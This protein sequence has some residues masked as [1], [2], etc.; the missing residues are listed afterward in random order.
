[1][2]ARSLGNDVTGRVAVGAVGLGV[3]PMSLPFRPPPEQCV[4]TIHAALDAGVRLLDTADA[5]CA[6]P[7]DFGHGETL[8]AQALRG[9]DASQVL[10][11]TKGGHLRP[12]GDEWT[13]DGSPAYLRRACEASLHRLGVEAIGLYQHHRPDPA[14][15]Y[16]DSMGELRRLWEQG[17]VRMV[18]IS[19]AS[20][21]Q[22]Q[23]ARDVL[24]PALVSVQNRFGP[25]S[26]D[27]EATLRYC[28]GHGL[29]FLAWAPLGS[30][31]VA[32]R[33][34]DHYPEL[35]RVAD[36]YGVS[37]QRACLAWLLGSSPVLVPIP[38]ASRPETAA[39]SAAAAGLVLTADERAAL[40]AALGAASN[41]LDSD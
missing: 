12:S 36:R 7:D 22:I 27:E 33:L 24:G 40:D 35:T 38:G 8:I 19:N 9:R 25:G 1:M 23:C 26:S 34:A 21:S 11:A 30:I 17:K 5:Y 15:A 2:H 14:V 16:E 39:D 4:R 18:G 20:V 32:P 28:A 3:L 41:S 37:V 31:A 13:V 29:A 10:V 6:G